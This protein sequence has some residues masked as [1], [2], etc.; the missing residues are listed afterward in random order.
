MRPSPTRPAAE[1]S[2]YF[3]PIAGE[4][5]AGVLPAEWLGAAAG[6]ATGVGG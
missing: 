1:L 5:P 4:I 2:R 3:P 6:I